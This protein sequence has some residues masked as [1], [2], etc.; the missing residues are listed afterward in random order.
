MAISIGIE[1]PA[2]MPVK[3][4]TQLILLFIYVTGNCLVKRMSVRIVENLQW[5]GL[6]G[7]RETRGKGANKKECWLA[8]LRVLRCQMGVFFMFE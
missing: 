8:V 2:V 7:F 6:G 4:N 3:G 5:P 1:G